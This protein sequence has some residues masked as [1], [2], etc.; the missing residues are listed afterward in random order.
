MRVQMSLWV[1]YSF[2]LIY[3]QKWNC[4]VILYW[5]SFSEDPLLYSL[6]AA[7]IYNPTNSAQGSFC[8]ITF[9]RSH[10]PFLRLH[11]QDFITSQRQPPPNTITLGIKFSICEL[12]RDTALQTITG[13]K[14]DD[15]QVLLAQGNHH[16]QVLVLEL[17]F[18]W[19]DPRELQ[20]ILSV[21]HLWYRETCNFCQADKWT[22]KMLLKYIIRVSFMG[23]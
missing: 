22:N 6:V 4:W 21:N 20:Y 1:E 3:S 5:E 17:L 18:G 16:G 10:I 23:M 15:S 19:M 2:L 7:S 12:C 9:I 8:G 14:W 13:R 11:H